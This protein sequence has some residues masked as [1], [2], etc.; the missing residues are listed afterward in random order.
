MYQL[1]PH[2]AYQQGL[3]KRIEVFSIYEDDAAFSGPYVDLLKTTSAKSFIKAQVEALC[4]INEST[5]AKKKLIIKK[6]DDLSLKTNNPQYQGYI[7]E[8]LSVHAPEYNSF[9]Q[10]RFK[11]GRIVKQGES[12]GEDKVDIFRRQISETI[13]LHFEKRVSLREKNIKTLSLFFIDKVDNYV[14]PDGIIRALFN[15]EFERIKKEFGQDKLDMEQVHK[16][17]FA[18]KGDKYLEREQ[19]IADNKEAY[20]LIM[21]DKERLLSFD[22]PTEFIFTHSALK[23]GWDNPNIFNI[24]T[25]RA[26]SSQTRKRQEIGRGMR[27]AVNQ[28]GERIF[29]KNVNLLSVIA[30]ESYANYVE[31]LQS[32]FVEDGILNAPP[33][34]ESGRKKCVA[35]LK[36]G[37]EQDGNF[38]ELWN[39]IAKKTA[40]SVSVDSAGLIKRCGRLIKAI[41]IPKPQMKVERASLDFDKEGVGG[42]I[43]GE[44][45]VGL[46]G[47]KRVINCVDFIKDETKLTARTVAAILEQADNHKALF[48]NPER[49]S[50]E[51]VRIIRAELVKDF[52]SQISYEILPESYDA[53]L[54]ENIPTYQNRVE[55]VGNSIYNSIVCDS[56]V[57][58]QFAVNL[59]HDERVKLFIK[60]PRWFKVGTPA[61]DYNPDWA[62][63]T[64]KI[65]TKGQEAGE[66]IYFVIETKGDIYNL[67]ES[68]R[69]KI[70]SAK[71][72][73]EVIAVKY[74]EVDSYDRFREMM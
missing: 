63:V 64:A 50:Y 38:Q 68:E 18:M 58:R 42:H 17:Y 35:K 56:D 2:E 25:L 65:D 34:P 46:K 37:F 49:F 7:V 69:Q 36:P 4:K 15:E 44:D 26:S 9:G 71:K 51:A 5:I 8:A 13:R 67:R 27:L 1:S 33:L 10:I 40:Y 16:G 32:E 48:N 39:R 53:S 72:H 21:K 57:E 52:L 55:Q 47:Q 54:F 31:Q 41:D 24:C 14:Q 66:K 23:E 20:E 59:N 3:V 11:N 70:E 61:G 73:F 29:D 62:I 45:S 6:G 12:A 22:E 43:M 28:D 74:K 19:S 30:N 60:L